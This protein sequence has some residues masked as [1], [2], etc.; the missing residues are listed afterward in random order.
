MQ[1][2]SFRYFLAVAETGSIR[3]AATNLHVSASAISRQIQNLEHS[4]KSALFERRTSGMIL[5]EE[6][7]IIEKH[8]RRTMREMELAR[9]QID[10][11]HGLLA[12]TVSFSTI[13][14]VASSWLL[15]AIV[16][17]QKDYPGVR[18]DGRIAASNAVYHALTADQVDFGIALLGEPQPEIEIVERFETGFKAAISPDH[19]LAGRTT[20][21]LNELVPYPLTMLSER[22]HTRQLLNAAGARRG[23]SFRIAFEMDHIELIKSFVQANNGITILPDYAV[24]NEVR[25]GTM[26]IADIHE[27]ELPNSTTVLCIRKGR[28]LTKAADKFIDLLRNTSV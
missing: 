15:P 8:M 18:F 22:F 16:T 10:D 26:A 1:I 23:L 25:S 19:D 12:G 5:T 4:F 13:E 27:G 28:R 7:R 6:G 24:V 21:Y 11:L 3:Q 2:S 17:F 14:G 9:A 20:L